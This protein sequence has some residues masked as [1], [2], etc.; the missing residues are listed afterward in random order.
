[1]IFNFCIA[2]SVPNFIHDNERLNIRWPAQLTKGFI[3]S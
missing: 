2:S 1:M 3:R